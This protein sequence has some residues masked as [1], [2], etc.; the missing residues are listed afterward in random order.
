MRSI[1]VNTKEELKKAIDDKYDE[2]IVKGELAKKLNKAKKIN[3]LSK[4]MLGILTTALAAGVVTAPI[5]G[6]LSLGISAAAAVP[7]AALTGT[8]I[9][10]IIAVSCIGVALV[11]AVYKGYDEIEFSQNPLKLRLKRK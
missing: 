5:T 6:G 11:T 8:E 10:V 3:K 4:A 1:E 9:A 2:I 7:I